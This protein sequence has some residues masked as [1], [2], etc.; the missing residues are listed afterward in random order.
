MFIC[1]TD[2]LDKSRGTGVMLAFICI[3]ISNLFFEKPYFENNKQSEDIK[4]AGSILLSMF[5]CSI[6]YESC[7]HT[8]VSV[9]RTT[10]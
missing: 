3:F 5:M 1:K 4:T 8:L 6:R 9:F 7:L 2:I 10:K